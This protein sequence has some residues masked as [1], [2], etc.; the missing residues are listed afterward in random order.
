MLTNSKKK[1]KTYTTFRKSTLSTE[2]ANSYFKTK[3]KQKIFPTNNNQPLKN[4]HLQ[5]NRKPCQ[6]S[7]PKSTK[8]FTHQHRLHNALLLMK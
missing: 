1:K 3:P 4:A 8:S 6:P 5:I 7:G 2:A